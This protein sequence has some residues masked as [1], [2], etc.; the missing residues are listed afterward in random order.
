M[1]PPTL[2]VAFGAGLLSFL[3]P[4]TLPLLPGYLAFMSGLGIEEAQA[5]QNMRTVFTAALLFVL[6][7]SLVF[8]ALGA[9][10]SYLGSLVQQYHAMLV[11]VAGLFII[12]MA[13]MIIGLVQI[14]G[15]YRERRFH[16]GRVIGR[17]SA[18]PLGMA[19]AFGWVPCIGPILGATLGVAAAQGT[20]QLGALLLFAYALGLG[21]PFLIVALSAD[22]AIRALAPIRRHYRAV[23][24]TGGAVLLVM[25]VFLVIG[26]WTQLLSPLINWYGSL[27]LPT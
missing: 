1:N 4:C 7:F 3:S 25:G 12:L 8:V 11:R 5:R 13:L 10:A 18:L 6:G 20:A 9:T 21:V 23:N 16:L 15:L 24:V 14:P 17:W 26:E 22:R 27:N 2:A 19:F